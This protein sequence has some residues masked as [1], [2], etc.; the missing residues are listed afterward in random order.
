MYIY[1]IHIYYDIGTT[2]INHNIYIRIY[3]YIYKRM[4]RDPKLQK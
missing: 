3:I 2:Y 1:Y 4:I